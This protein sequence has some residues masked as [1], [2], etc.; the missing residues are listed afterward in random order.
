LTRSHKWPTDH[1]IKNGNW[2]LNIPRST[3]DLMVDGG[4]AI[5]PDIVSIWQRRAAH[6]N[7]PSSVEKLAGM[8]G[9]GLGTGVRIE[10]VLA[11]ASSFA[12]LSA[13]QT[14]TAL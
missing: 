6:R 13:N 10:N 9:A 3:I 8:M 14:G 5:R 4:N 1:L 11:Q 12:G 7:L 2:R